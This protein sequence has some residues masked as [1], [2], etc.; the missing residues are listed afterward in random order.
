MTDKYPTADDTVS[1]DSFKNI[2]KDLFRFLVRTVQ[3][4]FTAL[5]KNLLLFLACCLAGLGIAWLYTLVRPRYYET[6]MIVQQ[7][8][9]TRKAYD[10]IIE[11]LQQQVRTGS[12]TDLS[13][14]LHISP[15]A[16]GKI[17][18]IKALSLVNES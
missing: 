5:K 16:A 7:Q 11:N 10:G 13:K 15:A 1:L 2:L 17:L 12:L 4:F 14:E 18:S 8:I 6:E 3:F 9:L